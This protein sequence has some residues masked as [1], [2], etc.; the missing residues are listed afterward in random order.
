MDNNL[1]PYPGTLR[2][3]TVNP[4]GGKDDNAWRAAMA[5]RPSE[6]LIDQ[7]AQARTRM[8]ELMDENETLRKDR[9]TNGVFAS[10]AAWLRHRPHKPA[11]TAFTAGLTRQIAYALELDVLPE[12]KRLR[13][14]E[15]ALLETISRLVQ[16][17]NVL[18]DEVAPRR[19]QSREQWMMELK[20][21]AEHEQG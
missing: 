5:L 2:N 13:Q 12:V 6:Y 9:L 7:L 8:A 4:P 20:H 14:R 10:L 1:D 18:H 15:K 21:A 11:A 3:H 17:G 16:A 19:K